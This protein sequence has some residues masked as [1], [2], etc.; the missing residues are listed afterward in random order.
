MENQVLNFTINHSE[1]VDPK[2]PLIYLWEIKDA[3][4]KVKGRY[5]GKS[6]SGYKRPKRDYRFNTNRLLQGKPY[7]PNRPNGYRKS[8]HALAE[9]VRSGHDVS[10][11]FICNIRDRDINEVEQFY[12]NRFKCSGN[13]PWQLND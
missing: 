13:N 8:H 3:D 5:I 1:N 2:K 6:S 11:R 12:I 7:R 4:G 9:A 10:L